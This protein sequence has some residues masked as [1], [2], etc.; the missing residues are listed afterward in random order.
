MIWL[1][2]VRVQLSFVKSDRFFSFRTTV[3]R[4]SGYLLL[5]LILAAGALSLITLE[6]SRQV[7]FTLLIASVIVT[8]LVNFTWIFVQRHCLK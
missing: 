2:R 5:I 8:V 1:Y 6:T 7:D 3:I 4:G